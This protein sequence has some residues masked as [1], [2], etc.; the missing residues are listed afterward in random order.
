MSLASELRKLM[1]L[2]P[3]LALSACGGGG[4]SNAGVGGGAVV[5]PPP[6]AALPSLVLSWREGIAQEQVFDKSSPANPPVFST[7]EASQRGLVVRSDRYELSGAMDGVVVTPSSVSGNQ[8]FLVDDG[9]VDGF[10]VRRGTAAVSPDVAASM[11]FY[12][13]DRAGVTNEA[14]V[15]SFQSY[16]YWTW[17]WN[18]PASTRSQGWYGS[19]SVGAQTPAAA[20]PAS[21]TVRFIGHLL[22]AY[23]SGSSLTSREVAAPMSLD[24]DFAGRTA[25]FN[26]PDW[27]D[28]G[29]VY[30]GTALS[31][32]LTYQAQRNA[33]SG[34]L[35]TAN[36]QMSGPAAA[37]FYGPAAQE[38]GGVF[39]L[40]PANGG[41]D[42][43]Y[44]AFGA[45]RP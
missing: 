42:R 9:S 5:P 26:S 24:V 44:G 31:G 16:G 37:Q 18:D 7:I 29:A 32:V 35:T 14:G 21:G 39:T 34:V 20:I 36:G 41:T 38:A 1:V 2:A 17:N 23:L 12:A 28:A 4:G 45:A 6:P 13:D 27:R 3:C 43:M 40:S 19:F 22:G 30:P 15:V 25:S 8:K 11:A 33:L 10:G